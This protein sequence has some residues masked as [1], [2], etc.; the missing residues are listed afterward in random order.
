M[1]PILTFN[2]VRNYLLQNGPIHLPY[3]TNPEI[4]FTASASSCKKGIR[5]GTP[6]IRIESGIQTNIL[7]YQQC[8]GNVYNYGGTLISHIWPA[9]DNYVNQ[10]L[11]AN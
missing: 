10:Q 11:N 1:P 4:I 6:A 8:W 5:R 2:Q 3:L 7:I 9:L